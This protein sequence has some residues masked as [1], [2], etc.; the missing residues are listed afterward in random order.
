MVR[1]RFPDELDSLKGER[2]KR[3]IF[4]NKFSRK[5]FCTVISNTGGEKKFFTIRIL[6]LN[7]RRSKI[8]RN[9]HESFFLDREFPRG[10][11]TIKGSRLLS[12]KIYS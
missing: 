3:D 4:E 10:S 2:F 9:R 6:W 1:R 5:I 11:L 12:S 8:L 7:E